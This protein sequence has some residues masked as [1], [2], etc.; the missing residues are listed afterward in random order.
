MERDLIKELNQLLD[1]SLVGYQ[2]MVPSFPL[3]SQLVNNQCRVSVHLEQLDVEVNCCLDT[4]GAR[5]VSSHVVGT[6]ETNSGRERYALI[7]RRDQH[8]PNAICPCPCLAF[9]QIR[10]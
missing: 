4:K 6:V 10:S 8:R 7:V 5:F 9:L 1:I 3:S 2:L